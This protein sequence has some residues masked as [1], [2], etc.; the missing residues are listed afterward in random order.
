MGN[1]GAV[2]VIYTD[3]NDGCGSSLSKSFG[4]S[5]VEESTNLEFGASGF[6]H[7]KKVF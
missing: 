5:S 2:F 6:L 7:V 3:E 4:R 1:K